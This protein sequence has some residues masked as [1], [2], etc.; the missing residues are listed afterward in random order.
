[1]TWLHADEI[2]CKSWSISVEVI[3]IVQYRFYRFGDA[4]L[5]YNLVCEIDY[6]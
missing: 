6:P 4:N 2:G 3:S 5:L 1:M